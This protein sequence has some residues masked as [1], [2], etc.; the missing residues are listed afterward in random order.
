M[1]KPRLLLPV[2]VLSA[3]P[4]A[5]NPHRPEP[6]PQEAALRPAAKQKKVTP[7]PVHFVAV[8]DI[9]LAN[10]MAR[11]M[12]KKGA[13][14]PFMALRSTLR[15]ADITFGNLECCISSRGAPIPKQFNFE[16]E[17]ESAVVLKRNGFTIVSQANNHAWDFGRDALLD[18]VRI[19]RATGMRTVGAGANLDAAHSLQILEANGL[20]IGF[21]AY[22]GLIPALIPESHT[23]PCLAMAS[24]A[25]ITLDVTAAKRKVDFL[26]VSLHAGQEGVAEPTPRQ[27]RFAKAAI[28]AGADMVIGHHPHVRQA[29]VFYKGRPIAYSLG[30]FV[31]SPAGRGSGALLKATLYPDKHITAELIPL[32]LSGGQPHF[33]DTT[34]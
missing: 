3:M 6:V 4:L 7:R 15:G 18:S 16:A 30:N 9:S 5:C 32:S 34:Q 26:L 33:I 19:V 11:L 28:D 2:F 23:L 10:P 8:G 31:F 12:A 14:Y 20:K 22:L 27:R 24:E 17:P 1:L 13:D 21:L 25:R 29:L